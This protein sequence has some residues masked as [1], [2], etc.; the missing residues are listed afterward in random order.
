MIFSILSIARAL[1][2]IILAGKRDIR[3]HSSVE[4]SYQ[5]LKSYQLRSGKGS[6]HSG[7][8]VFRYWGLKC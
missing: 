5:M 3:R 4:T 6:G 2:S 1:T 8:F 7:E